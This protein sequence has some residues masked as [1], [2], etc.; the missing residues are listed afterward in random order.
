[1]R[2]VYLNRLGIKKCVIS[3]FSCFVQI[4][5]RNSVSPIIQITLFPTASSKTMNTR[6][7]LEFY[8]SN[9][10]ERALR[11]VM[12]FYFCPLRVEDII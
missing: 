9:V 4:P 12:I 2:F 7:L 10:A 6:V 8:Q 1:M 5:A 11:Y 3:L